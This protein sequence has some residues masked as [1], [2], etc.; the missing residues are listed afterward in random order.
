MKI[1]KI[2]V[3]SKNTRYTIIIGKGSL[4]ILKTQL[5][6][7]CPRTKKVGLILDKNIPN[8]LRYKLKNNSKNTMFM[9]MNFFLMKD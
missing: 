6:K 2:Y 7:L 8:H 9:F 1:N 5:N 4:G 3:K